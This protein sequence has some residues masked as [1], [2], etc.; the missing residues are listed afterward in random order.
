MV[1]GKVDP[2][3][4]DEMITINH[5][6]SVKYFH[7]LPSAISITN[8]TEVRKTPICKLA[9]KLGQLQPFIAMFPQE[10]VGQLASFGPT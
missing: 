9:K 4:L 8:V 6:A 2:V 7:S 1:E 10:C 3:A 5:E